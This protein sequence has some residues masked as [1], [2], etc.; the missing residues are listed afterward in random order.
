VD[1]SILLTP[2]VRSAGSRPSSAK[3]GFAM[4]LLGTH[5]TASLERAEG[6]VALPGTPA[7]FGRFRRSRRIFST[8][9]EF[10][11]SGSSRRHGTPP[12]FA[13]PVRSTRGS[14][15]SPRRRRGTGYRGWIA[16]GAPGFRTFGASSGRGKRVLRHRRRPV[17][18][19][20]RAA[21]SF[22]GTRVSRRRRRGGGGSTLP[23]RPCPSSI[24]GT[25]KVVGGGTRG[26]RV[27]PHRVRACRGK[28]SPAPVS[29]AAVPGRLRR[30]RLACRTGEASIRVAGTADRFEGAVSISLPVASN[31]FPRKEGAVGASV[32]DVVR[33][34]RVHFRRAGRHGRFLRLLAGKAESRGT[35]RDRSPGDG[36][37]AWLLSLPAGKSADYGV[38][39]PIA[40]EKVA[41]EW[42]ISGPSPACAGKRLLPRPRSRFVRFP[43]SVSLRIDGVRPKRS[44]S[45]SRSLRNGSRPPQRGR[46]PFLRPVTNRIGMDGRGAG[47]R[48]V[49]FRRWFPRSRRLWERRRGGAPL[50][51]RNRGERE[52]DGGS[53]SR[54]GRSRRRDVQG[55]SVEVRGSAADL[56]GGR[57]VRRAGSTDLW[58]A[59]AEGKFGDGTFHVAANGDGGN[60]TGI[61]G[62]MEGIEIAQVFSL[63]RRD[64][65]GE[66]KGT[67]RPGSRPAA[68]R[69]GGGA[70]VQ[71]WDGRALGRPDA[72]LGRPSGRPPRRLRRD[73]LPPHRLAP[74][75]DRR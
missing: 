16:A 67:S 54:R 65:P 5:V 71:R 52:A 22:S 69:W 23:P 75:T 62:R 42:E 61:E 11:A 63:L 70:E 20:G 44:T 3:S 74:G 53:A 66:V 2:P 28:A 21:V 45:R 12:H 60:G 17:E 48:P 24:Q 27:L 26:R 8:R 4:T 68:A 57:G 41:G 14:G 6:D 38:G 55:P 56:A 9:R 72:G 1:G 30:S 59:H 33:S 36:P 39:E 40:W 13:S 51:R 32:P 18:R 47:D 15:L 31:G 58:N 10:F 25:R 19:S 49:R 64:N 35:A 50:S 37:S 7:E 43:P 73:V 34:E 29:L 46:G